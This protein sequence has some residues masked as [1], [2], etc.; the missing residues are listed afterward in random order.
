VSVVEKRVPGSLGVKEARLF[1]S[2][3]R[4][5]GDARQSDRPL[6]ESGFFPVKRRAWGPDK[7]DASRQAIST[8]PYDLL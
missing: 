6:P 8:T 4:Q 2:F 5:D 3:I 1:A 7:K